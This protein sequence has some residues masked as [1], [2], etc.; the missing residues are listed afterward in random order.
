VTS[1]KAEVIRASVLSLTFKTGFMLLQWHFYFA[2]FL[3]KLYYLLGKGDEERDPSVPESPIW[4]S[5]I[6]IECV[7]LPLL[8]ILLG[9]SN[10]ALTHFWHSLE[11]RVQPLNP[12]EM[13]ARNMAL[14]TEIAI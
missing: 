3:L 2:C 9:L 5:M 7:I 11:E 8:H 12:E 1:R 4:D 10:D 14:L 6:P 13:Y